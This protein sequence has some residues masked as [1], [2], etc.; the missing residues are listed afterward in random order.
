M[1]RFDEPE[2]ASPCNN[3]CTIDRPTG[4]CAGCYRTLEE[5]AGWTD[6]SAEQKRAVLAVLVA[7]RERF[8]AAIAARRA[9]WDKADG[10]R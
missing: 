10:E 7:R 4:L 9:V 1:M 3:V 2:V 8:G 6:L 5:I